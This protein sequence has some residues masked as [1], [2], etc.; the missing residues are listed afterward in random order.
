MRLAAMP[1]RDK[2]SC[3]ERSLITAWSAGQTATQDDAEPA[4]TGREQP[5]L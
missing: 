2:T 5:E 3:L 4:Q 1:I